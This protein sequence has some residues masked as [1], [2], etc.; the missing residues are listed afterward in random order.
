MKPTPT[1][2]RLIKS[3]EN[4]Y[5]IKFTQCKLQIT[6]GQDYYTKISN[7]PNKYKFLVYPYN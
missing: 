7:T 3:F 6:V 4:K 1:L 2:V 5:V